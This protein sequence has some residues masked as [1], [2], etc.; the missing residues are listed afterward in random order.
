[1]PAISDPRNQTIQAI[2][3][4]YAKNNDGGRLGHLPIDSVGHVCPRYLWQMFRWAMPVYPCA[5]RDAFASLV[6]QQIY[7]DLRSIGCEVHDRQPNG[8]PWRLS[9]MAG[10]VAGTMDAAV[11]GLPEA[12]RTWHVLKVDVVNAGDIEALQISGLQTCAPEAYDSL[13]FQMGLTGME[14]ALYL[15]TTGAEMYEERIH[16]NPRRFKELV[17][18]AATIVY[19]DEPPARINEDPTWDLCMS[20]KFQNACHSPS[21]PVPS[22]RNCSHVTPGTDGQ[23]MCERHHVMLDQESQE[24]GC[25]SHRYIPILLDTFATMADS[26]AEGNWVSYINNLTGKTFTNGHAP[27][28]FES[29]EIH[30][31]DHKHALDDANEHIQ[32]LRNMFNGRLVA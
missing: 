30:A 11:L 15:A 10:H 3:N 4:W 27:E 22:C 5:Q 29:S 16:A 32:T 20:C 12:A 31:L 6:K 17:D 24:K 25:Q 1:M 18:R 2:Q 14:R 19:S 8:T 28:A 26:S 9:T 7:K 23:W 13:I 21:A